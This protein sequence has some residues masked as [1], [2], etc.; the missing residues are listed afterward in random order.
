[1]FLELV[2][3][4]IFLFETGQH[5]TRPLQSWTV[6]LLVHFLF[7]SVQPVQGHVGA[8][9]QELMQLQQPFWFVLVLERESLVHAAQTNLLLMPQERHIQLQRNSLIGSHY[10]LVLPSWK[11]IASVQGCKLTQ[12]P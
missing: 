6:L 10:P 4:P 12:L 3:I 8:L 11:L 1:M 9:H 2:L 7:P 5:E